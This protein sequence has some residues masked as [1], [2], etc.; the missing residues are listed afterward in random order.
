LLNGSK[1]VAAPAVSGTATGVDD[2]SDSRDGATGVVI[3]GDGASGAIG[4]DESADYFA[5][6][7]KSGITYNINTNG[8]MDNEI[9]LED[10]IGTVL[11][12]DNNGGGGNV[13]SISWTASSDGIYYLRVQ[14]FSNAVT[15]TQSSI[16]ATYG[17]GAAWGGTNL[18]HDATWT[19]N[20]T[21]VDNWINTHVE[22]DKQMASTQ[23]FFEDMFTVSSVSL[24]NSSSW[25]SSGST[26]STSSSTI[27]VFTHGRMSTTGVAFN[28]ADFPSWSSFSIIGQQS[29]GISSRDTYS[30]DFNWS[31]HSAFWDSYSVT[32]SSNWTSNVTVD[33]GKSVS[34]AGQYATW[35][36]V[37]IAT[38]T[39][40]DIVT[41]TYVHIRDYNI[42][43]SGVVQGSYILSI[44]AT[45]TGT[46]TTDVIVV[47]PEYNIQLSNNA[48]YKLT[49][50]N[51]KS[52]ALG[53]S[54]PSL[55]FDSANIANTIAKLDSALEELKSAD[56]KLTSSNSFLQTR[57]NFND[58]MMLNITDA[59]DKI[60]LIDLNEEAANLQAVKTRQSLA[61]QMLSLSADFQ[62][63]ILK[64][65]IR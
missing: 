62:K 6:T 48:E 17:T 2:H 25:T 14:G 20:V 38:T 40:T 12:N 34:Y 46:T 49:G 61:M 64:L 9:W 7:A 28:P 51:L 52:N 43:S 29:T 44:E 31:D 58:D 4:V 16:V 26:F 27:L 19:T 21:T 41:T 45:F 37:N 63:S 1:T 55:V 18:G 39:H 33:Y 42:V 11:A 32:A 53:I 30:G 65:F 3:N 57:L 13:D 10:S 36:N 23:V 56:V 54:A 24:R 35:D 8:G 59:A 47:V 22:A 5:F 15:T 60:S 50:K